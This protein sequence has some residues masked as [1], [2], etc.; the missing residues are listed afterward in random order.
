MTRYIISDLHLGHNNIINL[1]NRPF[2]SIE[3]MD[4]ILV[5]N[6]FKIEYV[7]SDTLFFL[8]DMGFWSQEK[9]Q[10]LL[11]Q[12]KAKTYLIL[13]N[14]DKGRKISFWKNCGFTEV[15]RFP[16][17]VSKWYWLSHEPMYLNESMPYVNIHGHIHNIDQVL[18]VDGKNLY[19]NACVEKINYTPISL[20]NLIKNYQKGI[21]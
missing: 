13:G 1:C 11:S 10:N 14:H 7:P 5:K 4:D 20:D 21:S 6:L 16:L 19:F 15:S 3:E 2:G 9:F 8:G 18:K 17:C 12:I